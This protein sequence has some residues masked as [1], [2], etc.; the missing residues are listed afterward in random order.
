MLH[1]QMARV[2]VTATPA[3]GDSMFALSSVARDISVVVPRTPGSHEY[4]HVVVPL[5][6][7]QVAPPST[8]TS[9]PPTTPPP[10]SDAVPAIVTI[11]PDITLA[12]ADGDVIVEVGAVKSVLACATTSGPCS[13]AGCTPMSPSRLIVAW[14]V[15]GSGRIAPEAQALERAW[16]G[17]RRRAAIDGEE[18]PGQRVLRTAAVAGR[19][20]A[21][22]APRAG[23]RRRIRRIEHAV[24]LRLFVGD[25]R[26]VRRRAA[27]DAV[28]VARL[29][30]DRVAA[31]ERE[32]DAGRA[33]RFDVGALGAGPV[34]V[35]AG[36]HERLRPAR[37]RQRCAEPIG[38]DAGPVLHV[39]AVRF[40]EPNRRVLGVEE[41]VRRPVAGALAA[42]RERPVVAHLVGARR[43]AT[44]EAAAAVLVIGLPRRVVGLQ[45]DVGLRRI[46]ADE[47][48]DVARAA[49]VGQN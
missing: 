21:H 11:D 16:H 46:V 3:A 8:D 33:R 14:R 20:E 13:V 44:I 4:V 23:E 26:A 32:M 35:V 29:P 49:R 12:A 37:A 17:D 22:V 34:L 18:L 15:F 10:V 39:E 2:T 19:A 42:R 31:H 27:V 41:E 7:C 36:R 5:A 48:R 47:E 45:Q 25:Q 40:E 38:V 28:L 9:T 1:G 6:R 43:R 30:E 24:V